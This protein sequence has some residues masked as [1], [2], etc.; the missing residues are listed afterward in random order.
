MSVF[1]VKGLHKETTNK[2]VSTLTKPKM[3]GFHQ[4]CV[5]SILS[6]VLMTGKKLKS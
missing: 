3:T 4:K 2:L 6:S 1:I 5:Y